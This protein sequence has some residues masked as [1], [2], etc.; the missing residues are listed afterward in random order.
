MNLANDIL[1]QREAA[2]NSTDTE[3]N[4]PLLTKAGKPH[5]TEVPLELARKKVTMETFG[6][7][8]K[9]KKTDTPNLFDLQVNGETI[10][11]ALAVYTTKSQRT[12]TVTI[13]DTVM[14]KQHTINKALRK[15]D[16]ET[17]KT[18][19]IIEAPKSTA[20]KAE[21]KVKANG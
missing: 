5:N 4:G 2:K 17:Q 20:K 19:E 16:A 9:R 10:G 13:G 15:F 8:V 14:E 12:W 6:G 11:S 1:K 3:A 18:A 7:P 21:K